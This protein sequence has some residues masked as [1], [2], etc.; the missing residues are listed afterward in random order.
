MLRYNLSIWDFCSF[1][2]KVSQRLTVS[3]WEISAYHVEIIGVYRCCCITKFNPDSS[4]LY[5]DKCL[6]NSVITPTLQRTKLWTTL[7]IFHITHIPFIF[8]TIVEKSVKKKKHPFI[9]FTKS[10][11][12][13]LNVP[14]PNNKNII[15]IKTPL[16][17]PIIKQ[18]FAGEK[19]KKKHLIRNSKVISTTW[20]KVVKRLQWFL[21]DRVTTKQTWTKRE[22][23]WTTTDRIK[24]PIHS[25]AR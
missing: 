13:I 3:V 11:R 10:R 23:Q 1:P 15:L 8:E 2:E 19:E 9:C 18:Q 16:L 4:S 22:W 17:C 25:F 6:I 7:L 21:H 20:V 5:N 14:R 24:H 12:N